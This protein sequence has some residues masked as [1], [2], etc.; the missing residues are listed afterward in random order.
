MSETDPTRLV[1]PAVQASALRGRVLS[2]L[3]REGD[4]IQRTADGQARKSDW[5]HELRQAVAAAGNLSQI[6]DQIDWD[7]PDQE[8]DRVLV[9][10]HEALSYLLAEHRDWAVYDVKENCG[11]TDNGGSFSIEAAQARLDCVR[12]ADAALEELGVS[13]PEALMRQVAA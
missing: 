9:G 1:V 4:T 7:A 12:W 2:L 10:D 8:L 11:Y 3:S 5:S 6:L 13:D